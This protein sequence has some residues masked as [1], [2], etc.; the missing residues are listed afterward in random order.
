MSTEEHM[1][2]IRPIEAAKVSFP[3]QTTL[4]ALARE[5]HDTRLMF[6]AAVLAANGQRLFI[7]ANVILRAPEIT[8]SSYDDESRTGIWFCARLPEKSRG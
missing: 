2:E 3:Q 4:D 5:L 8:L 6:A 7:P 1:G